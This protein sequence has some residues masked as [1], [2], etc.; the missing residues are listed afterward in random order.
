MNTPK[1]EKYVVRSS[2]PPD[3]NIKWGIPELGITD[4]Y[5]FLKPSGPIKESNTMLE[6]SWIVKDSAFG[7]TQ[8]KPPHTHNCDEI[9]M[10]MGTD[11]QNKEDLGGEIEFW[12]GEGKETEIVKLTTSGLIFVP[13]GLLHLPVFFKN[14]KRPL[15]WVILA[16]SIGDTLK[17]TV[18]HPVRQL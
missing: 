16:L 11:P 8:D 13:K 9:F 6:F 4:Q 7:V 17:D 15:L 14:V 1:Y 3:P 2:I 12:M 18:K 10:F 5:F